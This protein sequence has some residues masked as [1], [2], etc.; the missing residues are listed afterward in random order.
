MDDLIGKYDKSQ[1][2]TKL[3]ENGT[4]AL[5]N[6]GFE[7]PSVGMVAIT[8]TQNSDYYLITHHLPVL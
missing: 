3:Y 2:T 7:L 5:D 1:H 4:L 8:G 6:V